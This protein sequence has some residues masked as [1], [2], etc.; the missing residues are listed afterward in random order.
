MGGEYLR[1]IYLVRRGLVLT[2]LLV[3]RLII[4]GLLT[5][6]HHSDWGR[7]RLGN[8]SWDENTLLR[9]LLCLLGVWG[10]RWARGSSSGQNWTKNL[11]LSY[12]CC[13]HLLLLLKLLVIWR[14]SNRMR[15][16]AFELANLLANFAMNLSCVLKVKELG[17]LHFSSSVFWKTFSGIGRWRYTTSKTGRVWACSRGRS[18]IMKDEGAIAT[19]NCLLFQRPT[20][21]PRF[22]VVATDN[23]NR[24]PGGGGIF[25]NTWR[26]RGWRWRRFNYWG[27]F[28][29]GI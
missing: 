15:W 22:S 26:W 7:G 14:M 12:W 2:L 29:Y 19:N 8:C 6:G 17:L 13:G 3:I 18:V 25:G 10:R 4:Y 20:R 5:R 23:N 9:L 28:W 1:K 16:A 27:I 11:M 24:I 21:C